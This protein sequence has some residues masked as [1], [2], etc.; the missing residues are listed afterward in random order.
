MKITED[1][2][3]NLG[4]TFNTLKKSFQIPFPFEGLNLSFILK[5]EEL[6]MIDKIWIASNVN[7]LLIKKWA[8]YCS[9][10]AHKYWRGS[11]YPLDWNARDCMRLIA[12]QLNKI[13]SSYSLI[14]LPRSTVYV[15]ALN[16]ILLSR[17]PHRICYFAI[18]C[19]NEAMLHSGYFKDKELKRCLNRLISLLIKDEN[20]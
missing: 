6:Q 20:K 13:K 4:F 18:S 8:L 17:E 15:E 9:G 16:S 10:I 11:L 14:N 3:L 7:P 1:T 12:N 5:S 2:L 19:L